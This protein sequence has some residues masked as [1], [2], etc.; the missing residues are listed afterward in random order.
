MQWA[1]AVALRVPDSYFVELKKD[2]MAKRVILVD[3]L[4]DVGFKVFPPSGT[5]SLIVDRTPFGLENDIAFCE[6]LIKEVGVVAIPTGVFYLNP[7]E[8]K[9]LVKFAS[10][11][12]E[13]TLK[14]A[15]ER[16]KDKLKRK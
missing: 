3:G 2:Y 16:M 1:S 4:K 15:I 10:C 11:K 7:E 6:Y 13:A 14:A 8:G 5:Y 12:D 9:N